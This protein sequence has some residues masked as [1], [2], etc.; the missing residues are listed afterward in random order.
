MGEFVDAG[1]FSFSLPRK[2]DRLLNL[3][4]WLGGVDMYY[5]L[6]AGKIGDTDR[7]TFT[8]KRSHSQKMI[9]NLL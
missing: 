8:S 9:K 6:T 3:G 7:Y 2:N 4:I 5:R 1:I